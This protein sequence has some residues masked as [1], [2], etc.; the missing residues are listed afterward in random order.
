MADGQALSANV[1][2]SASKAKPFEI[3]VSTGT[4][5]IT[6]RMTG[7]GCVVKRGSGTLDLSGLS[8]L[9]AQIVVESGAVRLPNEMT[10][11]IDY[12]GGEIVIAHD[13]KQTQTPVLI[14]SSTVWPVVCRVEGEFGQAGSHALFAVSNSVKEVAA[15][16]FAVTPTAALG[17]ETEVR[18]ERGDSVQRVMIDV[19][20]CDRYT[21]GS[22][23]F[24]E[25]AVG[26]EA[27]DIPGWSGTGNVVA[28][29]PM[30]SAPP[31]YALDNVEH[32]KA[33]VVEDAAIRTYADNFG[34][35][36]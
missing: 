12:S 18:I 28:S 36:V 29:S 13:D 34:L 33:L 23:T 17:L 24:E 4:Y 30:I 10:G 31:S 8:E 14:R 20:V 25:C 21:I 7:G 6:G 35:L 1:T 9:D 22:D 11:G 15:S 16:D 27:A 19:V 2:V 5:R 26:D 3:S 32:T